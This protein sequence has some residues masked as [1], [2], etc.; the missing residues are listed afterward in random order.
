MGTKKA[1]VAVAHSM[2]T[3]VYHILTRREPFRELGGDYFDR[4]NVDD[5]R[6]SLVRKLESLG[7]SV[8]IA[9]LLPDPTISPRPP[10][11]EA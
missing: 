10:P 1:L 8:T 3:M 2:L 11:R 4:R 5:Q 7:F 6:K 9:P